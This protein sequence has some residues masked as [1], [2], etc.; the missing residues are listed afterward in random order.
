MAKLAFFLE[1]RTQ[2]RFYA[3]GR[4]RRRLL[5]QSESS[6]VSAVAHKSERSPVM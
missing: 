6:M 1:R 4:R 2:L 5:E 3:V